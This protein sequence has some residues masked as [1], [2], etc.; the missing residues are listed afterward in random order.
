MKITGGL[1]HLVKSE[2]SAVKGDIKPPYVGPQLAMWDQHTDERKIKTML[3]FG[4]HMLYRSS[5]MD[6]KL[7]NYMLQ[8]SQRSF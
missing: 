2:E 4:D 8:M 7:I 6:T 3:A 5:H 1:D